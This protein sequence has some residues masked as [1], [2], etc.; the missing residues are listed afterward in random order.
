MPC[1]WGLRA[2]RNRM[3]ANQAFIVSFPFCSELPTVFNPTAMAA[4]LS[5]A[6][7]EVTLVI[8]FYFGLPFQSDLAARLQHIRVD[9][10]GLRRRS[11][12]LILTPA[13]IAHDPRGRHPS[14]RAD[15]KGR[16]R[17]RTFCRSD[18]LPLDSPVSGRS[19]Q[20]RVWRARSGKRCRCV[21][22]YALLP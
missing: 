16:H 4:V 12:S 22:G 2:E 13:P 8:L 10:Q 6:I 5:I 1:R 19:V 20:I 21:V 7:T 17:D 9:A 11:W 14:I 15:G 3:D 18:R